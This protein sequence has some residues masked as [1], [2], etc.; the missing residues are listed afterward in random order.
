LGSDPSADAPPSLGEAPPS[1]PKELLF[2][3][4]LPPH[5]A[6]ATTVAEAT[7]TVRRTSLAVMVISLSLDESSKSFAQRA[8]GAQRQCP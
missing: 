7:S 4:L 2:L 1:E 8:S 5:P 6:H 3:V